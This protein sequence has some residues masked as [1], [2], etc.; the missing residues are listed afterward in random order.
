MRRFIASLFC[1]LQSP[2]LMALPAIPPSSMGVAPAAP[3][4]EQQELLQSAVYRPDQNQAVFQNLGLT[5][6][7]LENGGLLEQIADRYV[8][9]TP[10]PEIRGLNV[11]TEE[12][13]A[14]T[15][16]FDL[17]V[18]VNKAQTAQT[19]DVYKRTA[20]GVGLLMSKRVST[21][22]ETYGCHAVKDRATGQVTS[23]RRIFKQTPTGY[24]VPYLLD[25]DHY[26]GAFDDAHMPYA[27]FFNDGIATHVGAGIGAR[28]SHG[29]VRMN[30]GDASELF[31]QVL[32]TG[33][34]VNLDSPYLRARCNPAVAGKCDAGRGR[35]DRAYRSFLVDALA[36]G[37]IQ[38][39]PY[40]SMP[41][42]PVINRDGSLVADPAAPSQPL[43]KPGYRTLYIVQ[44]IELQP[45]RKTA[46]PAHFSCGAPKP[47][48]KVE[49]TDPLNVF[50]PAPKAP[51]Q[52]RTSPNLLDFFKH[53][54][55]G[56]DG[57]D[58]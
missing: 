2:W 6:D 22:S 40:A 48:T 34:P 31:K 10:I 25:I 28:H 21:G 3:R 26:S 35:R 30:A 12:I 32:F 19:I 15:T 56:S 46:I 7:E 51:V 47:S 42:V 8:P 20:G 54:T 16:Y 52:R 29:C 49:T 14:W 17:I 44:D 24:Y 11:T 39:R 43:L 4:T 37:A 53:L 41:M 5:A 36:E 58:I 18:V 55:Q 50:P 27:V 45:V 9:G 13:R 23:V 33:G 1:V 38:D 57:R